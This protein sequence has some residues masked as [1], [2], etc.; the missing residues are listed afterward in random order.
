L[1]DPIH[2]ATVNKKVYSGTAWEKH[3]GYCRARRVGDFVAVAGTTAVDEAGKVV[4]KDML[5][6]ARFIFQKIGRALEQCEASLNDVIRTRMF[7]TSFDDFERLAQAHRE[8]F[9]GIDP[10]AT[11]VQVAGL[12]EPGLLI[13]IEVDAVVQDGR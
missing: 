1:E 4:C 7:V 10:V 12:I 6:Q 8:V 2:W 9:A 3:V 5:G 13:E 11:C